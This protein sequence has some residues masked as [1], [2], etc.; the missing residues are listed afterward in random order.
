MTKKIR[1]SLFAALLAAMLIA[2]SGVYAE[3]YNKEIHVDFEDTRYTPTPVPVPDQNTPA[4]AQTAPTAVPFSVGTPQ[5]EYLRSAVPGSVVSFGTWNQTSNGDRTPLQWIVT[6][7]STS[8]GNRVLTLISLRIIRVIQYHE[9]Y[10]KT[11]WENCNLREWLNDDFIYAFTQEEKASLIPCD[12]G[13]GLSDKIW[14]PSPSEWER[15]DPGVR[16]ALQGYTERGGSSA[17][18]YS[19]FVDGWWLR[20][21]GGKSSRAPYASVSGEVESE[22]EVDNY[23]GVRP[24]IRLSIG[25]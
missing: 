12:T 16:N 21:E 8:G 17:S 7:V 5:S 6:E 22:T 25:N 4:P 19:S 15:M 2:A 11:T 1:K 23:S 24:M 9:K 10:A 13:A 18:L 14:L 3:I 20:G